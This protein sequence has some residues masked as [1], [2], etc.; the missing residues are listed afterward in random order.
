VP[1]SVIPRLGGCFEEAVPDLFF[2]PPHP[3]MAT[4]G[5][6][7]ANGLTLS[8][9][10][11]SSSRTLNDLISSQLY[12]AVERILRPRPNYRQELSRQTR[13]LFKVFF[14]IQRTA[15]WVAIDKKMMDFPAKKHHICI[16]LNS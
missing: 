15:A 2:G 4:L 1:G 9:N 11:L 7:V 12:P 16:W 14:A 3:G 5:Q 10:S 6:S 13:R 8:E